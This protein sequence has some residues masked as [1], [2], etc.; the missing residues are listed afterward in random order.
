[1]SKLRL[2]GPSRARDL[3]DIRALLRALRGRL[4]MT[5]VQEYSALFDSKEMLDEWLVESANDKA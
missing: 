4:K 2:R 5:E 1:M 3:D